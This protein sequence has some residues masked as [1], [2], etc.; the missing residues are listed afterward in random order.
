MEPGRRF[1][2][3]PGLSREKVPEGIFVCAR[4]DDEVGGL[5]NPVLRRGE[6]ARPM[7]R[8]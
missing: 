2:W 1:Y 8:P 3:V 7:P 4:C 6:E 5:T